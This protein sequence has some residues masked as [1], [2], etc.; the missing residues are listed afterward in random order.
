MVK[1]NKNKYLLFAIF[2]IFLVLPIMG[3]AQNERVAGADTLLR[4]FLFPISS[5]KESGNVISK[6]G[7][8]CDKYSP[9]NQDYGN[10]SCASTLTDTGEIKKMPDN[11]SIT[12]S[13]QAKFSYKFNV[14]NQGDYVFKISASN[15]SDSFSRLTRQQIDHILT[16]QEMNGLKDVDTIL[17]YLGEGLTVADLSLISTKGDEV[18]QLVK[19]LVFSVYVDGNKQGYIFVK[20]TDPAQLQEGSVKIGNLLPGEHII[21]L[22]F[23]SD[24]YY[25]F[26]DAW[27]QGVCSGQEEVNGDTCETSDAN[28]CLSAVASVCQN[29]VCT[30]GVKNG[31]AC[32]TETDCIYHGTCVSQLPAI[33]NNF[34]NADLNNN[35]ILDTNPVIYGTAIDTIMPTDDVIGIRIYSNLL[36]KDVVS[37]YQDNVDNAASSYDSIT[38]D[39]YQAVRD[40][41]TVY[42]NAAN[43]VETPIPNTDPPQTAKQFFTNIYVM[44]YNQSAPS[45]TINIFNQMLDNWVFNINV[46]ADVKDKLRRDMTRL[47][48]LNTIND[49]LQQ[50]Q[51]SHGKYPVLDAGT[52]VQGHS[53]ST[54][55]SWQATLGNELGSGLPLD[56]LNLMAT[57][58]RGTYNC[59]DSV[60]KV[61]CVN[62][63]TRDANN[64]AL[65]GCPANEQCVDNQYCSICPAPYDVQTC[66]DA[67]NSKF[68][69]NTY[70]NCCPLTAPYTTNICP[71]VNGAQ[72]DAK[73]N[74]A[75]NLGGTTCVEQALKPETYDGAYVYQYTALNGGKNYLLNYRLEYQDANLCGPDQC[76]F[77]NKDNDPTNDCYGP[78]S[79]L[80]ACDSTGQNCGTCSD[81]SKTT[82]A[83]C[84]AAIGTWTSMDQYK[85]KR[86]VLGNWQTSCNDGY[87]EG[88]CGEA[89]DPSV[90]LENQAWCD[91]E[92]GA[93]NWYNKQLQPKC[94]ASCTL[95]GLTAP[96]PAY[97]SQPG[98]NNCGGFCGDYKTQQEYKE[99]CDQGS[100][101]AP[102]PTPDKGGIGG[103]STTSQYMCSGQAG[104]T[105]ISLNGA[106]CNQFSDDW[107]LPLAQSCA[108]LPT[109][110][111]SNDNN[112][113]LA[114]GGFRV[115]YKFNVA[116]SGS[117][118][119][120]LTTANFG[121]D[122]SLLTKDQID[123]FSQLKTAGQPDLYNINN[124]GSLFIPEYG[125]VTSDQ[126]YSLLR[127]LIYS[128]YLDQ[129]YI[130]E[131]N[132]GNR[133]GFIIVPA[134]NQDKKQEATLNLGSLQARSSDYTV[135]LHFVGDHFYLPFDPAT[136]PVYVDKFTGVDTDGNNVL[137]IN[138]AIFNVQF[139]SPEAN[140]GSC[141]SFGGYCGDREVE[142]QYGE[143]CDYKNY[144]VPQPAETANLARN[145]SFE[146][147][148][149]P[150]EIVAGNASLDE[151]SSFNGQYSLLLSYD[152]ANEF[153]LKQFNTFFANKQ[154]LISL[155]LKLLVGKINSLSF[156]TGDQTN[157]ET[158]TETDKVDFPLPD[159][160]EQKA[161]WN[162]YQV[163]FT[164]SQAA[165]K[166]R[167]IFNVEPGTKFNLDEVKIF[168]DVS[169][170]PQ[171][172]CG[173]NSAGKRCQ[174]IGGYCSDGIIQDGSNN[175]VHSAEQ[176][177]DRVGLSCANS[178][179]CG[180]TG[181]CEN[182]ICLSDNC[183]D[184]CL[185][186]YC[187]DGIVQPN[188]ICDTGSDPYC[189]DGCKSI[190]MGGTCS[191][192][193]PCA[194]NLSCS[195]RNYGDYDTKC[196]GA[197]G[198]L[199]C[200]SNNDCV[201]G[202]YCDASTTKCEPEVSSY[203]EYHSQTETN[204][205]F[206]KPPYT[207]DIGYSINNSK[208]PNFKVI[209]TADNKNLLADTCTG[210]V[211]NSADNISNPNT[212]WTYQ[213]AVDTG[214]GEATATRLPNIKELYSLVRQTNIGLFYADK[215]VLKLCPLNCSY[216]QDGLCSDCGDDNY[217]YWSSTCVETDANNNCLSALA[218]NF[219]YGSIEKYGTDS[220][221]KVHCLRETKCGNGNLELG[222]TCE[223]N[224]GHTCLGGENAGANCIDDTN[225]PGSTCT[226]GL[227]EKE[228][229]NQSC[230]TNGYDGGF[231]HCDPQTCTFRYDNC[232]NDTLPN[233]SCQD[234]CQVKNLDCK[235]VGTNIDKAEEIYNPVTNEFGIANNNQM[236]S[237]DSGNNCLLQT[238][239]E[240]E[241]KNQVNK[242]CNYPFNDKGAN[243]LETGT[244]QSVPAPFRS[245]YSYCNCQPKQ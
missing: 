240:T 81:K 74:G 26:Y 3:K 210:L 33:L 153:W 54:W 63:C 64:A 134:T 167:I 67:I 32:Q 20:D 137:D 196:L 72:A 25:N 68:A 133:I 117:Y 174:Y 224:K 86:C 7:V 168:P 136:L 180:K 16:S 185:N 47:V 94:T 100:V 138:P 211:W 103:I 40:E 11:N 9:L 154:Y 92:Y 157:S 179:G 62:I 110:R 31:L 212:N 181:R 197:R 104:G 152:A 77:D 144:V 18:Y 59:Q 93:H 226:P 116:K 243:C 91:L 215:Q 83:D 177:D 101:S 82:E 129:D 216:N 80:A 239:P 12:T 175:T 42:V 1:I 199:G 145:P 30:G 227:V 106:S 112:I 105:P 125:E 60:E 98:V 139:F 131:A 198:S 183:S 140:V 107:F 164:P 214:C 189:A 159:S 233:K 97:S 102:I 56:P 15:D 114:K 190:K 220:A 23:L 188:E 192:V 204:L 90:N 176:C 124:D 150:W 208:C 147:I 21:Y 213:A 85:D 65:T 229:T 203:L 169:V 5:Y 178:E 194:Q 39:G 231:L 36:K 52:F 87:I 76:Y 118:S 95:E 172:Q 27:N 201:L 126:K 53:L 202:Y 10:N 115:S 148:F 14:S 161:G 111:I 35:K 34:S 29:S 113:L 200:N 73:L 108:A 218:I 45:E 66:W 55:P 237:I 149:S 122:L 38:V 184:A 37:W 155:R 205:F 244:G 17:A 48:D 195:I 49:L 22:H 234:I 158:W 160:N 120:K 127:S 135:Y 71:I 121:D 222:E 146:K 57:S 225:C 219:K 4:E 13:G 51:A 50:Y 2:I 8:E 75:F 78:G 143:Q 209:I 241:G 245:E 119:V 171:Y 61:N 182:G 28:A 43:I 109:D 232:Y 165:Y 128:V 228:I 193:K 88:Q 123:Y 166:F 6:L 141:Q 44:A 242:R 130:D 156:Q 19:N 186:A 69:L 99:Q 173:I 132:S 84:K 163:N 187:G 191:A 162:L 96:P 79:C 24:Y 207:A 235:A 217:L 223:F 206:P 151:G 230:K 238:I 46:S 58:Q 236:M 89:C 221:F 142:L 41:R 170:R 70:A